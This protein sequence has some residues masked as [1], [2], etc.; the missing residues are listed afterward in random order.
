MI[1]RLSA[2]LLLSIVLAGCHSG[3]PRPQTS[4]TQTAGPFTI[5][6]RPEP[7]PPHVGLDTRFLVSVRDA[8]NK[9]GQLLI[10]Q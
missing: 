4:D 8:F 9:S 6:F 2:L 1:A 5:Q 10:L 7:D 3:A